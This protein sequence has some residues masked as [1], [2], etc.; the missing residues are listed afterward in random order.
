[1]D[2]LIGVL[3][4]NGYCTLGYA[5]DIAILICG[6]FSNT[7]SEFLQEALSMVQQWCGRTQLSLNPQKMVIAP[8][9]QKRDLR[10]LKEPTLCGHTVQLT[11]EV[12]CLGL[13]LDKGLTWKTQLKNVM[14]KD[15]RAFWTFKGTFGKTWSPKPG[16]V[17]WMYTMVIRPVLNYGSMVWWPR[18]RYNVSRTEL[19]KLQKQVCLAITGTMKTTPTAAMEVLLGLPPL[20]MIEAEAQAEIYRLMCNQQ[21]KPKSTN[22]GHTKKSRDME[23]EPILQ[24]RS[25]RMLLRYAYHKPFTVKFPDKC[26]WQNRF[27]LDSKGGLVWYTD[28]SKT[29][30]GT[31]A[32][33]YRWGLSRGHSFNLGLHTT[34]F[35]AEIYAIKACIMENIEKGYTGRNIS[36][37]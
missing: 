11:T 30:E 17:H 33:V 36:I 37:L 18:V 24:M 2:E 34:V 13:I 19:S 7:V 12:K 31:G 27:N 9:T 21:W 35:H 29:N 14:N 25:D 32:G 23:H 20:V 6:K 28:G 10:D 4:G 5:D 26:E 3:S 16:V 1:V 8:F 15:Y 22:F